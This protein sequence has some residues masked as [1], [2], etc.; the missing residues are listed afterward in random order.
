[1]YGYSV[2]K[3]LPQIILEYCPNSDLHN[4]ITRLNSNKDGVNFDKK[5]RIH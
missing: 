5:L 2:I 4:Y 1:M 3:F